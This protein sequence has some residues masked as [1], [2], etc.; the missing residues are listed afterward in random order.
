[1]GCNGRGLVVSWYWVDPAFW[2]CYIVSEAH[3][4]RDLIFAGRAPLRT[5]AAWWCLFLSLNV[6]RN[7]TNGSNFYL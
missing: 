2:R 7:V 1:M 4:L 3:L 5:T 6:L